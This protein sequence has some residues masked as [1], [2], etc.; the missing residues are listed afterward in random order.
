[1]IRSS[2]GFAIA[3]LFFF[4]LPGAGAAQAPQEYVIQGRVVTGVGDRPLEGV[5]VM[6]EGSRFGTLTGE[7]GNYRLRAT[8][9]PGDYTL[10]ASFIGR[11]TEAVPVVLGTDATLVV[12]AILLD[13]TAVER[14]ETRALDGEIHHRPGTGGRPLEQIDVGDRDGERVGRRPTHRGRV[15]VC[16]RVRIA[17]RLHI[18]TR[19]GCGVKPPGPGRTRSLHL[20]PGGALRCV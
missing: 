8:L 9:P 14:R 7:G 12:P 6:I 1:M 16:P 19:A 17:A 20:V 18:V 3:L 4:L 10:I 11:R 15:R 5:Q 13:E 2:V